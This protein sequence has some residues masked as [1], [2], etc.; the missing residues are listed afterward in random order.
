MG[1]SLGM[2]AGEAIIKG[3]ETARLDGTLLILFVARAARGC[4]KASSP[5]AD[6]AHHGGGVG[7]E[8]GGPALYRR[9]DQPHHRRRHGFLCHAGRCPHCRARRPH[10]LL[11]ARG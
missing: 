7:A 3:L 6:A 10:R 11:A 5:Y 8:G 1:G 2:A 9:V 4:R